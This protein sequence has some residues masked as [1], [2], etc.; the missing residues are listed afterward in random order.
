L[1]KDFEK[2]EGYYLIF[3]VFSLS[4]LL[5]FLFPIFIS[6]TKVLVSYSFLYKITLNNSSSQS[7][8]NTDWSIRT[9]LRSEDVNINWLPIKNYEA[10]PF[11][12]DQL[13]LNIEGIQKYPQIA[14]NILKA[15]WHSRHNH[16][17]LY[18]KK[19]I[20][21]DLPL[22]DLL[23]WV[24]IKLSYKG[25]QS[26]ALRLPE[27]LNVM[28]GDCTEFTL[29]TYYSLLSLGR[30]AVVPVEGYYLPV[31]SG[32]AITAANFHSWL[33]VKERGEWLVVDPLY[34]VVSKPTSEYIITNIMKE[35]GSLPLIKNSNLTA[36]LN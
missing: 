6:N 26:K 2:I 25:Y 16:I 35:G 31:H 20:P 36:R 11:S 28:E 14:D 8:V 10:P 19:F 15:T 4:L 13:V 7:V 27:V 32:K 17:N 30:E 24:H 9:P 12:I 23:D 33:L 1:K 18:E 21:P 22:A 5:V 3:L 29:F 34:Q